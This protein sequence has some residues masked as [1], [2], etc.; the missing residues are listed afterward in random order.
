MDQSEYK[1]IEFKYSEDESER[2]EEYN[3]NRIKTALDLL[4]YN[5]KKLKEDITYASLEIEDRISK[6]QESFK[7]FCLE[8]PVVSK[9]IIAYGMFSTKAFV[10]YIDWKCKLRPSDKMRTKLAGNQREQERFKN[11]YIYGMYIKFLYADKNPKASLKEIN[12]VYS[13]N[14]NLLNKESD[15]FF[16]MYDS[17]KSEVEAKEKATRQERIEDLKKQL[18]KKIN[19]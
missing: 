2:I 19:N 15:L 12:G 4:V 11:K 3:K 10:K 17:A 6:A 5:R 16:D 8:F 13:E 18:Q 7:E 1:L 14:V 9:Y